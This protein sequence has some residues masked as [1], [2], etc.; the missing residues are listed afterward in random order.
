MSLRKSLQRN[1]TA[2][3]SREK[4]AVEEKRGIASRLMRLGTNNQCPLLDQLQLPI[5]TKQ[6]RISTGCC[7]IRG[8]AFVKLEPRAIGV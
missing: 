1:F 2:E 6:Y 5:T 7:Q 3:G 4:S 8:R